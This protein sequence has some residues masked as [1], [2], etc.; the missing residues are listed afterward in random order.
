MTRNSK[1]SNSYCEALGQFYENDT[2]LLFPQLIMVL[3]FPRHYSMYKIE[4]GINPPFRLSR[5]TIEDYI[6]QSFNG[7]DWER[8]ESPLETF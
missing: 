2:I 8:E 5:I 1:W 6:S 7:P 4:D 3:S